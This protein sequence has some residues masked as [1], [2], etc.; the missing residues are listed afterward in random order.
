MQLRRIRPVAIIVKAQDTTGYDQPTMTRTRDELLEM[1]DDQIGFLERSNGAFDAGHL[2]EA[3]QMALRVR[4]LVYQTGNSH[5]LI[6]QLGL[7][8]T[9]QWVDTA[10]LPNPPNRTPFDGLT[11][12]KI[13]G[14]TVEY[15]A[16]LGNHPPFPILTRSGQRIP[17]GSL[18]PFDEWWTNTVIKDAAGTEFSRRALVKALAHKEG[19]A[20]VDPV[21]DPDYEALAKSNSLGWSVRIGDE[22]PRPMTQN[23]VYPSMRQISY[24]VLESLQQQ[25]GLIK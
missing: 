25:Q 8:N 18:I 16:M 11:S 13:G 6:N 21:P 20:H 24:E 10:G 12:L 4:V 5:G 22:D 19:G 23:P 17:A 3:L 2:S 9:L 15:V 7:E 14:G 1:L